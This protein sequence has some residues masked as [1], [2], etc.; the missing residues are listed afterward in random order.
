MGVDNFLIYTNDCADGTDEILDRLQ[1]MGVVCS[2]A[3]TTTGRAIRRSN[4]R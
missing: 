4:T 2:T 3:T 1:E